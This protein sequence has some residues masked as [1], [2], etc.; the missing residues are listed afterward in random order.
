MVGRV[1]GAKHA[2]D[3]GTAGGWGKGN[4][5]AAGRRPGWPHVPATME[6]HPPAYERGLQALASGAAQ[7]VLLP[8]PL[9]ASTVMPMLRAVPATVLHAASRSV[10][11]RSGSLIAAISRTCS[12]VTLPT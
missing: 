12:M 7:A 5:A 3:K 1:G 11:F 8:L 6:R 2:N 10:Q 4:R 9:H